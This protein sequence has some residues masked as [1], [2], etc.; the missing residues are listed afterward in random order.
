M[1]EREYYHPLGLPP[2]LAAALVAP[3]YA[4][5]TVGIDQ[6]TALIVKA[7][8][9][10]VESVRGRV[11]IMLLHE[12]YDHPNAP[13]VR[14]ALRIYDQPETPLAMETFINVADAGQRADYA[15]LADQETIPLLF[16]D[17]L[18]Q[19]RLAKRITHRDRAVVPEILTVA[20]QLLQ[21][22]PAGQFDFERAKRAVQEAA[23]L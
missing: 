5:L 4:C 1:T 11:P 8:R 14:M 19:Q 22:I 16:Y 17:E 12:L 23:S 13:V 2:E 20:D 10:E 18:L 7:P 3:T 6:G 15:A 21:R 9:S